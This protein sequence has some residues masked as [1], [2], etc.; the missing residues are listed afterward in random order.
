ME[1]AP[2]IFSFWKAVEL[3]ALFFLIF[4]VKVLILCLKKTP[5]RKFS[6]FK[7]R[8]LE[9]VA[10]IFCF[11]HLI[12]QIHLCQFAHLHEEAFRFVHWR[13]FRQGQ[14]QFFFLFPSSQL[15]EGHTASDSSRLLLDAKES[16][17]TC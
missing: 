2:F 11:F 1:T 8:F 14:M 12:Q 5:E 13:L 4:E 7:V 3:A 10:R 17:F 16:L 9:E 15:C 6:F